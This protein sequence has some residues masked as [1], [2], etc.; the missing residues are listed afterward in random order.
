M[1]I[2]GSARNPEYLGVSQLVD[3][4]IWVHEACGFES[5]HSDHLA[6][7]ENMYHSFP[8]KAQY[9]KQM[10]KTKQF[11]FYAMK[12]FYVQREVKKYGAMQ[13]ALL[14]LD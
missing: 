2:C 11:Y 1:E 3:G 7:S 4:V 9:S 8:I 6:Q 12:C 14:S 5:H 13:Q 10:Y